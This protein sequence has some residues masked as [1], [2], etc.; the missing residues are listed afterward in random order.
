MVIFVR[1]ILYNKYT[2]V[3]DIEFDTTVKRISN[4]YEILD[5]K[6]APLGVYN[7]YNNKS[8]NTLKAL[9][10][11]FS[12][13]GIPSWRKDLS[14]LLL[15]LGV[16]SADELLDKSYGLSLS[17]QYWFKEKGSSI[18]WNDIN[19]FTNPFEYTAYLRASLD[20]TGRY[21]QNPSLKSPTNT[22][23]GM[24][25]KAWIIEDG[26]RVLV[27]GTY[28]ASREE[29]FNEWLA[30]RICDKLGFDYCKYKLDWYQNTLVSKCDNFIGEDEEI[31][32]A[33][34]VFMSEKKRNDVN[35]F[36]HYVSILE[37]HGII[38]AREKVS[39]MYILDYLMVN[40]D[41]HMK[42]F[43]IIRNVESLEWVDTTPI[44][45]SG[46]SM[47]CDRYTNNM[48]FK[49]AYGKFFTNTSKNYKQIL[50]TIGKSGLGIDAVK[51]NGIVEEYEDVLKIYQDQMDMTD[52]RINKLTEGLQT[53]MDML[54]KYISRHQQKCVS[55]YHETEEADIEEDDLML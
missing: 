12:G 50:E 37:D 14:G 13:R 28:T 7:A 40:S 41:R 29:P 2:P 45:D 21:S 20:S 11:W 46:Q 49:N 10:L 18:T 4:I 16:S 53:R 55:R 35:D 3:A 43:G 33:Y 26:R 52:R 39:D 30:S 5:I 25:Q 24:L 36:E 48:D 54:E 9:N 34:D 15:R 8:G 19:F 27:K 38:D 32:S 6:Y 47:C 17:D 23:D 42:N 31:I 51:L 22:T 44:F 1:C